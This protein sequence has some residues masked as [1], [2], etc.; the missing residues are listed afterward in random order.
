MVHC[1]VGCRH[2]CGPDSRRSRQPP[3]PP[4]MHCHY[5]CMHHAAAASLHAL[6]VCHYPCM[7]AAAASQ[8]S[9]H[10]HYP[11]MHAAA[12]SLHAT[13]E[14]L[15][16]WS[17]L[18]CMGAEGLQQIFIAWPQHRESAWARERERMG[19]VHRRGTPPR[20]DA[21]QA[22]SGPSSLPS[23]LAAPLHA[24]EFETFYFGQNHPMKPH[25]LAMTHH[26]VLGYGLH[27]KMDVYVGMGVW[28]GVE[29][30]LWGVECR[31]VKG[32]ERCGCHLREWADP[33]IID[34]HRGEQ[35]PRGVV[36]G[37]I[38]LLLCHP[39]RRILT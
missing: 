30:H 1:C 6:P 22:P 5:P 31:G 10:C 11:C 24:G 15:E 19:S 29:R 21:I 32:V 7:H 26:L 18:A 8:P 34:P 38:H 14:H 13:H 23:H 9:T 20:N 16:S 27:K 33:W 2:P 39:K 25:R 17:C 35:A 4:S 37:P 12:A 36:C 28:M 3:S